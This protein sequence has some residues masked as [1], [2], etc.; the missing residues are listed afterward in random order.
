M[1]KLAQA[2]QH[3]VPDKAASVPA[4]ELDARRQ[5]RLDRHHAL[6]R[7]VGYAH[8]LE[9]IL[10]RPLKGLLLQLS[11]TQNQFGGCVETLRL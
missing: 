4:E 8:A 2:Q 1:A 5:H 6:A 11:T 10:S 9:M 7:K 3:P